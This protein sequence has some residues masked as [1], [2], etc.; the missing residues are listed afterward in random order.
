ML[1]EQIEHPIRKPGA[2]ARPGGPDSER[3][4]RPVDLGSAVALGGK[5][6]ASTNEGLHGS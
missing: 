2:Q 6:P 5:R 4:T 1:A 3:T